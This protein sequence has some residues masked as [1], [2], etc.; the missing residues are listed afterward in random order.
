M[1]VDDL[2]D[3]ECDTIETIL[4]SYRSPEEFLGTIGGYRVHLRL[5]SVQNILRDLFEVPFT[6]IPKLITTEFSI[7]NIIY[8]FRLEKGL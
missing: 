8:R 3:E 5:P 4:R 2:T 7:N 1:R 6:D